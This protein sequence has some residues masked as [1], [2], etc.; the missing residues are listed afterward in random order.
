MHAFDSCSSSSTSSSRV[1]IHLLFVKRV[2]L[3]SAVSGGLADV[4]LTPSTQSD[5][6]EQKGRQALTLS[7][8]TGRMMLD[9]IDFPAF[10]STMIA[11]ILDTCHVNS[12]RDEDAQI[13]DYAMQLLIGSIISRP[14]LLQ[15][16]YNYN[17]DKKNEKVAAVTIT[18]PDGE[19]PPEEPPQLKPIEDLILNV[20]LS[21]PEQKIR[22]A[23]TINFNTLCAC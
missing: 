5:E 3:I 21:H 14:T 17:V 4:I 16:F 6:A 1:S 19:K 9:T 22:A 15:D 18:L 2:W 8:N 23:A 10:L 20:T 13:V 11:I 12:Q 7:S